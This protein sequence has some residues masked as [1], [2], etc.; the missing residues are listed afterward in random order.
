VIEMKSPN[1]LATCVIGGDDRL[2]GVS[3]GFR[4]LTK[5]EASFQ[6]HPRS[7]KNPNEAIGEQGGG[8]LGNAQHC[9]VHKSR[10]FNA[11]ALV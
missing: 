9:A 5:Y 11:K 2:P 3:R 4:N 1:I 6:E 8:R 7:S 10:S